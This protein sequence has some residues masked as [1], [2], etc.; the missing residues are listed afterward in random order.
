M[1]VL[2]PIFMYHQI[3]PREDPNFEPYL[4]VTPEA[5][6]AQITQLVGWGLRPLTLAEAWTRIAAGETRLKAC[7]L[8]FDDL[9]RPFYEHAFPILC[10]LGV[11]AT[12]FAIGESLRQR[13]ALSLA[14]GMGGL[15]G[16]E[17]EEMAEAGI[18]IAAH[19]FAHTELT[20]L[21]D[22]A[23]ATD[24]TESRRAV[25]DA[26]GRP[27]ATLAYPRGRFS[28]RVAEAAR[29]AGYL[30]ACS[31]LRGNL[32]EP[33][34]PFALKRIRATSERQGLKLWYATTPIYDWWNRRRYRRDRAAFAR[35]DTFG[36]PN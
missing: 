8:T 29:A 27:C 31:T 18:E 21:D 23:L 1:G 32:Q 25:E 16:R 26:L 10:E 19:G 33:A 14:S 13:D 20:Y 4:Y 22:E 7:V 24:L 5:L 17:L 12:V 11:P 30:C 2:L 3:A 6:R 28:T 34:D 35:E 9:Y 15:S 36:A